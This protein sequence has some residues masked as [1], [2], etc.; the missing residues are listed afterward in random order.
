[1]EDL[2]FLFFSALSGMMDWGG[3]HT[4]GHLAF[5][6]WVIETGPST[7]PGARV[8]IVLLFGGGG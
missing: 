5:G 1:M 8:L 4:P 2:R 7:N 3:S 6:S